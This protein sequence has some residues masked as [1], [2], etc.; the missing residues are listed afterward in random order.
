MKHRNH[1]R[2]LNAAA[3]FALLLCLSSCLAVSADI[4]LNA[5]GSGT[6]AME[7]RMSLRLKALGEQDGN[8]R[9]YPLPVGR[10][11]FERTL[12]RLPGMKLLSFSSKEDG[13]D[14]IVAASLSFSDP[15]TLTA[16]L[17][18]YG[19]G[20][21]YSPGRLLLTLYEGSEKE[22]KDLAALI[23]E[24]SS[25]YPVKIRLS[26][27]GEGTLSVLDRSGEPA[28]ALRE[29]GIEAQGKNL[30]FSAPLSEIFSARKGL[31]LDFRWQEAPRR[32]SP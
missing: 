6:I 4:A 1:F 5:D 11:D 31:T 27:P 32:V 29:A 3:V 8:E 30:S 24:I 13:K 20:A 2:L 10:A 22:N 17:D 7:Y 12:Q 28:A 9:W 26:L 23:A 16:F 18:A 25:D 21:V 19:E 14:L 15:A